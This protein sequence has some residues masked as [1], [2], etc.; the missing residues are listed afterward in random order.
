MISRTGCCAPGVISRATW[1]AASARDLAELRRVDGRCAFAWKDCMDEGAPL[2]P[3]TR[4][5]ESVRNARTQASVRE[6]RVCFCASAC[7]SVCA[8]VAAAVT[9]CE[10]CRTCAM[11]DAGTHAEL[12][13][14]IRRGD[15]SLI[16][17]FLLPEVRPQRPNFPSPR[18]F[19]AETLRILR[20]ASPCVRRLSRPRPGPGRSTCTATASAAHLML[21]SSRWSCASDALDGAH[22]IAGS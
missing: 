21:L 10:D 14:L 9:A 22:E 1:H 8:T 6:P 13:R 15:I 11:G 16:Y 18:T 3:A 2:P 4:A 5:R 19:H 20:R 12:Q 7:P 17:C